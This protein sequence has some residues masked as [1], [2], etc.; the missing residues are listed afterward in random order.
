MVIL[1]AYR[2]LSP[3]CR[4]KLNEHWSNWKDLFLTAVQEHIPIK[5]VGDKNSPP[6]IDGEVRHLIRK[7]YAAL[8]KFRLNKSPER[9]LKV[10]KLSQNIKYLVRS[11]HRQYLAKIEASFKVN[12]KEF[13]SYHRVFLGGRSCT[14]SAISYDGE[15]ATK[16]AQKAELLNKYFCSVF[17]SA[18]RDVN[19]EPTNNS[20]RTDLEISQVQVSVDDV[21]KHLIGLD[22]SKACGPDGIPARLLKECGQQIAPSLCGIFNQSLSSGQIPTE[23]KSTNITPIHKKDSKE[24]AE[25]YRPISLLPIVS[26]VLEHCIF[27]CLYDHVNNLITPLQ[28]GFLRNRSCVIQ[29]LSVLHTIGRNLDKNI[30]TDV[31]YLDYAKAFDTVDHNVLLSKLK[32]YGVSGQLLTWFAD[33]L[34]GRHQRVVIDGATSQ[35]APVTSGVPQGSLLGPMLFII[36]INDLPDVAIGDVFTSLY[37]DDTK[38]YRNINTIEDCMSMQKTLINM[39]TWTRQNNIRFNASKCKAL[40]IIRKKRPL[41]FIYKLDNVELERVSTEKDVGVNI[42][43]SLTWNTHIHAI[44]AK[45]NKLLGLLK[46]TCPL[47]ND[48]SARRSLYLALVKSQLSYATQVWS[49]HKIA[50]KT[51]IERVQRRATRWI[52]KQRVGVMSYRDRLLTLKLLPLTFDREL[53]DL[54][55]FYKCLNGFTDINVSH[56]VSFVSHGRTR[57]SNSYN[58]KTPVC[59][60]STFQASYFNRIVKLWNYICKF[61]PPTSFSTPASF[62]NFVTEHRFH[63]LHNHFDIYYPCTWSIVRSCPCHP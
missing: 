48:V 24:P 53:K 63:L 1:I 52:L 37:A 58:L 28:H 14:N 33:Y 11:K 61:S 4:L 44:I 46:R 19:T 5:T 12:P 34:S 29:L 3:I 35:W 8:K 41:N 32:A 43:N 50:L 59:K 60:T 18:A 40:T 21:T 6:W 39:D 54:V 22:T 25:N 9:K 51:Q 26:K 2:I 45:A 36:F 13:W 62:C 42:T 56:F 17:L 57:Q 7:K 16:P 47:L 10:R 27:N 38:V 15:V 30:Q 55:F 49:P 23:W 20:L 31:I